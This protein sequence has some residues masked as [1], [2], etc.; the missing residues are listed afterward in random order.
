MDG[1]YALPLHD[2]YV[3]WVE[4]VY[5]SWLCTAFGGID[6]DKPV[7]IC[8]LIKEVEAGGA[9]IQKLDMFREFKSL[10]LSDDVNAQPVVSQQNVAHSHNEHWQGWGGCLPFY[11]RILAFAANSRLPRKLEAS[12]LH[13]ESVDDALP[14]IV[15]TPGQGHSK[16]GP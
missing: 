12:V 1:S 10:H 8:H 13:A 7:T 11:L 2:W 14:H 6:N 5:R 4:A 9:P 3:I 16:C 15:V